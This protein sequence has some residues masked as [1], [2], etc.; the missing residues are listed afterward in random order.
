MRGVQAG[1]K[2]TIVVSRE[3]SAALAS[4]NAAD[5][6]STSARHKRA[7]SSPIADRY[8]RVTEL[9]TSVSHDGVLGV[10]DDDVEFA[11]GL[12]LVLDGLE[13]RLASG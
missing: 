3:R 12:D 8:P 13:R 4:V 5:P 1:S 11:F 2:T 7:R 10:C 9:A 6:T